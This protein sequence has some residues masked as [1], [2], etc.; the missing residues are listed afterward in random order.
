MTVL[1]RWPG[2]RY[3][4]PAP[5]VELIEDDF[6]QTIAGVDLDETVRNLKVLRERSHGGEEEARYQFQ[7]IENLQTLTTKQGESITRI[8]A[9]LKLKQAKAAAAEFE[10]AMKARIEQRMDSLFKFVGII[11]AVITVLLAVI[12]WGKFH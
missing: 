7:A 1:K 4:P 12:G 8:I 11:G 10:N 5:R 9:S 3:R 2:E 6:D